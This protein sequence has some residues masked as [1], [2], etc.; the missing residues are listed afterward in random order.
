MHQTWFQKICLSTLTELSLNQIIKDRG[1]NRR[2]G[3]RIALKLKK[4]TATFRAMKETLVKYQN[5]APS[6]NIGKNIGNLLKANDS[7]K[8]MIK[9]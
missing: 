9:K 1:K 8:R 4:S 7:K 5:T 3:V 2:Y 6:L